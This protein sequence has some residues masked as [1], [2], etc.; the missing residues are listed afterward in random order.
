MKQVKFPQFHW[1]LISPLKRRPR[2]TADQKWRK[3]KENRFF[4]VDFVSR[5]IDFCMPF[6]VQPT[7]PASFLSWICFRRSP[8]LCQMNLWFWCRL[9]FEWKT[10]MERARRFIFFVSFVNRFLPADPITLFSCQN[11]P[12]LSSKHNGWGLCSFSWLQINRHCSH[13]RIKI[14]MPYI[15]FRDLC[16]VEAV[17][18]SVWSS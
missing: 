13:Q 6:L 17:H 3:R 9:I 5:S 4:T 10:Q 15:G 1:L 14:S 7:F 2:K 8:F 11:S 18:H 12:F 16:A